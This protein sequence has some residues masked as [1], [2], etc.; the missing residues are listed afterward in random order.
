MQGLY[1]F[2]LLVGLLF[3]E[4]NSILNLSNLTKIINYCFDTNSLDQYWLLVGEACLH[5]RAIYSTII[6]SS[7]AAFMYILLL[8]IILI[9][10]IFFK[11]KMEARY[12]S[13]AY[14]RYADGYLTDKKF[15][16]SNLHELGIDKFEQETTGNVKIDFAMVMAQIEEHCGTKDLN[17]TQNVFEI[18]DLRNKMRV[19]IPVTIEVGERTFPLY[20]IYTQEHRDAYQKINPVLKDNHFENAL[21]LSLIPI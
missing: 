14:F 13:G 6:I 12:H 17:I 20:L 15:D 18:Y 1:F 2:F 4:Y 5:R 21:Y 7:I 16:F 19:L 8:P 3:I 11:K 10:G 9:R